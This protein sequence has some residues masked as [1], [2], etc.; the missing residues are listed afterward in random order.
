VKEQLELHN[1]RTDHVMIRS[2]LR[3]LIGAKVAATGRQ[4]S[5]LGTTQPKNHRSMSGQGKKPA[6]TERVGFLARFGTE[7]N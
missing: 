5:W 4:N 2:E 3:Q 6:E 7:L 1:L